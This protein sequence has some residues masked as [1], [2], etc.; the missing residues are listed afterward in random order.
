MFVQRSVNAMDNKL[1]LY[2]NNLDRIKGR[3]NLLKQVETSPQT[4]AAMVAEVAR[5][6]IFVRHYLRVSWDLQP[7]CVWVGACMFE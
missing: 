5:R 4:Y 1:W 3:T 2:H 6:R 7:V